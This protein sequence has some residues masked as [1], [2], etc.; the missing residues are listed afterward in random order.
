MRKAASLLALWPLAAAMAQPPIRNARVETRS[1]A[2]GLEPVMRAIVAAQ[3][4]P[5]WV[6]YAVP[7]VP[8]RRQTCWDGNYA[9]TVSLE[10]PKEF[11]ILYR[12]NENRIERIRSFSPDC[13]IDAGNP[14]DQVAFFWL[15]DVKP[16]ESVRY[17]TSLLQ[18]E[19]RRA[20]GAMGAIAV[21]AAPEATQALLEFAHNGRTAQMRGQA[22]IWLAETAAPQVSE[23]VIRDAIEN[24]PE[25]QVK[26]EAV[27][28]L[29]RIPHDG[30]V[31]L[32]IQLARSHRNPVV[33]KQ[34]MFWLG[35]SKDERATRFFE[36]VLGR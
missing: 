10:G 36:E 4:T 15:T 8:G 13:V 30:G 16:A 2:S 17:L 12:M 19:H 22:L 24:A 34:A 6:G 28:A 21:H 25:T 5:A 7:A 35:R 14:T 26:R 1:A 9:G 3:G 32:L 27:T 29:A 11:Y 23:P 33:Q 31:P 18:D 20:G